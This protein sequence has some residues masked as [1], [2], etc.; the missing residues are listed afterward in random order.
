VYGIFGNANF[1]G[2][3]IQV[4]DDW[5]K[6]ARFVDGVRKALGNEVVLEYVK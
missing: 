1:N 2:A 3:A 4:V 6:A 5:R